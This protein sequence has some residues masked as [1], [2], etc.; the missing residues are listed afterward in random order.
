MNHHGANVTLSDVERFTPLALEVALE[1]VDRLTTEE[2]ERAE[3][4]KRR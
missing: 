1:W 4:A 2:N 3:E